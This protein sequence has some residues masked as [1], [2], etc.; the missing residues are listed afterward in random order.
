MPTSEK[1]QEAT[2]LRGLLRVLMM[3]MTMKEMGKLLEERKR[4][5]GGDLAI[6]FRNGGLDSSEGALKSVA[7]LA[8]KSTKKEH[9]I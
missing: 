4:H 3:Q 5:H 7:S 1:S 9:S 6:V 8:Q 2:A